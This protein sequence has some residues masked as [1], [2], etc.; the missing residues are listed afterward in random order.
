MPKAFPAVTAI[1]LIMAILLG[2]AAKAGPKEDFDALLETGRTHEAIQLASNWV[3]DDGSQEARFALGTAQFLFAVERLGHGFYTLGLGNADY[4]GMWIELLGLPFLRVPVPPNPEAQAM[5]YEDLR[6]VLRRF[7][8]DLSVADRTLADV[9]P[10]EF[11]FPLHLDRIALDFNDDG[12]VAWSEQLDTLFSA[13]SPMSPPA[14]RFRFDFDQSDAPW[15]RAYTHLLRAMTEFLL[16]HDWSEAFDETFHFV[17]PQAQV[18]T[19]ELRTSAQ[20]AWDF[21]ERHEPPKTYWESTDSYSW[22]DPNRPSRE[23]WMPS[24]EGLE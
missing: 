13:V 6:D 12:A 16:A 15:L 22:N 20:L 11:D 14:E 3:Q 1:A 4:E 5:T 2:T 10:E 7:G 9:G 24:P 23:A 18:K 8:E 19:S 17:L 21:M